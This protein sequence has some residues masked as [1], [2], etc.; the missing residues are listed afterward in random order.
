[1]LSPAEYPAHDLKSPTGAKAQQERA[2]VLYCQALRGMP[3]AFA[4]VGCLC[5]SELQHDIQF[6]L[7]I[8]N[9]KGALAFR[10]YLL[11]DVRDSGERL[12]KHRHITYALNAEH[13]DPVIVRKIRK[14]IESALIL[15]E[16]IGVYAAGPI[17][18][19]LWLSVSNMA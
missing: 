8:D 1:M 6:F 11:P 5:G 4:D 13:D 14:Q 3:E 7:V 19:G 9:A 17:A 10:L 15:K 12:L 18:A 2:I 16:R